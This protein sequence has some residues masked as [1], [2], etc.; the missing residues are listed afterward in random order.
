MANLHHRALPEQLARMQGQPRART[1][2]Q[3]GD[4]VR[5]SRQWLAQL[6]I[7][8]HRG[9]HFRLIVDGISA[10]SWTAFQPDRGRCF[11]VIVD[12]WG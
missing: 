3:R 12:D 8:A 11:S 5:R 2:L 6:R 4:Y 7:S 1:R 9:R 10:G